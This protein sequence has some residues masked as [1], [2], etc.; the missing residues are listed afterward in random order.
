MKQQLL[1]WSLHRQLLDRLNYSAPFSKKDRQHLLFISAPDPICHTQLFPFFFHEADWRRLYNVEI[2]EIALKKWLSGTHSYKND[3]VDA[4]F[5]QTWFDLSENTLL[6]LAGKIKQCYP[7]VR[8]AYGDWF[9][10]CD[11]RYA[12]VLDDFVEVYFKKQVLRDREAYRKSTLGDT[13]LTDYYARRFNLNEHETYF[14]VPETFWDK[15]ILGT[16]FAFSPHMMT[17]FEKTF[18]DRER[19]LDLHA[20]I[21]VKGTSWYS[22][23]RTEALNQVQSLPQS[24]KVISEGRVDRK[25]YFEELFQSKMCCSPFGYGEVCWRDFEAMFTGSLLLKPDMSHI[26]SYP[27]MFKPYET[28]VP[29]AW[30][31]SDFARQ[32]HY[33]RENHEER[34]RIARNAFTQM[35]SYFKQ[36]SFVND[37]KPFF[38]KLALI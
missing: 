31:W 14:Q 25:Q 24:M 18:P 29:L 3:N 5:F 8:L 17:F 9:A 33:Y 1:K 22:A 21:A 7:G 2:R 19:P 11:L 4:V 20:R 27:D 35:Q 23:M 12:A 36:C 38:E 30:D 26:E 10:P 16:H 34:D 13:N 28:Y 37:M 6:D 32:V 15:L